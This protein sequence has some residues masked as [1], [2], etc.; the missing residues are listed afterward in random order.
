MLAELGE[1]S[2]GGAETRRERKVGGGW[3]ACPMGLRCGGGPISPWGSFLMKRCSVRGSLAGALGDQGAD[4]VFGSPFHEG[5][6]Q[7]VDWEMTKA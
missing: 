1:T 4:G 5:L 3:R 6:Y 2:R 7:Q